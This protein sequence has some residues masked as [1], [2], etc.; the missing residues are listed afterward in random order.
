MYKPTQWAAG[1]MLL[2]DIVFSLSKMTESGGS[3]GIIELLYSS[4]YVKIRNQHWLGFM[5]LTADGIVG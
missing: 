5:L 2:M 3:D 4:F 1:P